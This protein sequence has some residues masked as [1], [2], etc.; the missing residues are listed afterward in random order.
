M[1]GTASSSIQSLPSAVLGIGAST[2]TPRSAVSAP[3]ISDRPVLLQPGLPASPQY[4]VPMN[5]SLSCSS[6]SN[7][8]AGYVIKKGGGGRPLEKSLMFSSVSSRSHSF[9]EHEEGNAPFSQSLV[10][11]RDARPGLM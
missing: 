8:S 1:W 3:Y 10:V 6:L 7:K 11:V 5:S 9:L 2:I 4:P